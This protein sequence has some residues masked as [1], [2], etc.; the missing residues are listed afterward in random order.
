MS[1]AKKVASIA[2]TG[3]AAAVATGAGMGVGAGPAFA[4]GGTWHITPGGHYTA[5]NVSPAILNANGIS[6]TC[7]VNAA[8]ASGSLS[9]DGRT[10][11]T[12]QLGTITNAQF[13]TAASPCSLLGFGVVARLHKATTLSATGY[14]SGV[15]TGQIGNGATSAISASVS[16]VNGFACHMEIRGASLPGS[17]NNASHDLTINR[18]HASQ[19]TITSI[20]PS[21]SCLGLFGA[22]EPAW[23]A[24]KYNTSP[25]QTITDP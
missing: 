4:S 13:G 5:T 23:F 21:Q 20:A 9:G 12:V 19:L 15:T 1:K 14:A 18:G 16:G 11:P 7:P 22:N 8:T 10:G 24:A 3:A 6:L 17:F 2:F 25:Q